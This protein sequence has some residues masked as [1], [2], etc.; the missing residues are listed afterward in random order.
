[1]KV[2]GRVTTSE[3]QFKDSFGCVRGVG[4]RGFGES[5]AL[6]ISSRSPDQKGF[7]VIPIR[8]IVERTNA[9]NLNAR[10]L[11]KEHE[12]TAGSAEAFIAIATIRRSLNILA[13]PDAPS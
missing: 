11:A 9:W 10:R 7:E 6:K 3:Q 2:D 4:D 13:P 8:W 5:P 1:S 12:T